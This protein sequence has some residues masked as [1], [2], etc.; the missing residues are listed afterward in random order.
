M[1][2]APLSKITAPTAADVCKGFKPQPAA[3]ALMQPNHTPAEYLNV[4]EQKKMSGDAINVLA[5]GM[6]ERE[7]VHYACQSSQK[8]A[9]QMAPADK[10]AL[11]AAQAWVKNPSEATKAK[12]AAAAAKTDHQ[13]PG[14]WAAQAAA[15]SSSPTGAAPAAG[16]TGHAASGSVQLASAMAN[17]PA[18]PQAPVTQSPALKAP[19]LAAPTSEAPKLAQPELTPSPMTVAQQEEAAKVHQPFIDLG[20]DIASGKNSWA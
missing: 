18:A 12:A 14:A 9:G 10:N 4:L 19:V 7:S 5:H 17:K 2:N 1:A 6:P 16:L 3:Q 15:F 11:E 13:G 20:K 8:V